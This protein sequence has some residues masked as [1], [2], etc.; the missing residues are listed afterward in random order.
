MNDSH[1]HS[2]ETTTDTP[3]IIASKL[4]QY[5]KGKSGLNTSANVIQRLSD[6]V[7]THCDNAIK[8]AQESGRKTVMG[9]DFESESDSISL[10]VIPCT[11]YSTLCEIPS[12][13][14][15]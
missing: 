2:D 6:I 15:F 3:L 8:Q 4:K 14:I 1:P 5:I 11:V 13:E 12:T 7:R 10:T 9:R